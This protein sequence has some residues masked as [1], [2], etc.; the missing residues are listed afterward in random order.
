MKCHYCGAEAVDGEVFCRY[1]GTRQNPSPLPEPV[2][3][4]EPAAA[5][6]ADYKS[7]PAEPAAPA[8]DASIR[9]EAASAPTEELRPRPVPQPVRNPREGRAAYVPYGSPARSVFHKSPMIQLPAERSLAKM[10]FLGILTLG[11]YPL[12]IWCRIVTELNIAASRYDGERTMSYLG[13]FLLAPVTLGVYP[14]VWMHSFC[15]RI[16]TELKRRGVNYEF[17]AKT[18]WLWNVLGSFILVGPFIFVHKLMRAMNLLNRDFN[19]KG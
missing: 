8:P 12:V 10:F 17:G 19:V 11:I 2:R 13:A 1:C 3:A 18:F 6:W 5:N 9:A 14:F 15:R 4:P 7:V 16:G